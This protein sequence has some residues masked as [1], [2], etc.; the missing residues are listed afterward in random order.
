MPK[1]KLKPK[2]KICGTEMTEFFGQADKSIFGVCSIWICRKLKIYI[3]DSTFPG[4]GKV[5]CKEVERGKDKRP[6]KGSKC[7]ACSNRMVRL[8]ANTEYPYYVWI[9]P[10][11]GIEPDESTTPQRGM[12]YCKIIRI[13]NE[14]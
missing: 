8:I 9:C 5:Y 1:R 13:E 6:F 10:K 14:A 2:C 12:I 11:V 3:D 7:K 4:M